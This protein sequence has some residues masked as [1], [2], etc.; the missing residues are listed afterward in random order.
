[1]A[2]GGFD[3]CNHPIAVTHQHSLP[4]EDQAAVMAQAVLELGHVHGTHGHFM[5]LSE[6]P[7]QVHGVGEGLECLRRKS[8]AASWYLSYRRARRTHRLPV[9]PTSDHP[10]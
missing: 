4:A 10:M 2:A 5:S 1:M 9:A 3:P 7:Q 6:W 8:G